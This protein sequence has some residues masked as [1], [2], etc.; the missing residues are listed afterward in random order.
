MVHGQSPGSARIAVARRVIVPAVL[1]LAVSFGAI[2]GVLF[3]AGRALDLPV[4]DAVHAV[5]PWLAAAFA[6]MTGL[7]WLAQRRTR[8]IQE[9]LE[10]SAALLGAQ[11]AELERRE[12]ELRKAKEAVDLA[13]R[14]KSEFLAHLSHELRTPLNAIAGFSEIIEAEAYGPLGNVRYKEYAGHVQ[15]SARHMLELIDDTLDISR[16]EVGA[17]ELSEGEIDLC[18]TVD[19]TVRM[20]SQV[21]KKAEI[22][23]HFRSAAGGTR[24]LADARRVRQMAIN[25]LSNAIKFTEPGGSATVECRREPDGAL[26]IAVSDT[27]HGIAAEDIGQ[28]LAPFT[29]L[30]SSKRRALEGAGI[31]LPLTH[32]LIQ[33]HGGTLA[34]ES[35]PGKG[36][37]VILRF[38]KERSLGTADGVI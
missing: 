11:N 30:E 25:L 37:T 7:L 20:L 16:A 24:L 26:A 2:V 33:L 3:L 18:D 15:R 17:L 29:R 14:S 32:H 19:S 4:R 13:S 9:G 22:T 10:R 5:L 23:I 8:A 1:V 34:I 36:T 12:A 6:V 35:E 21:A 27:G 31:G 38:P 28:A